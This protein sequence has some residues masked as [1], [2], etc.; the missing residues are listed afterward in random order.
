MYLFQKCKQQYWDKLNEVKTPWVLVGAASSKH[1]KSAYRAAWTLC[2]VYVL[3]IGITKMFRKLLKI[4][5]QQDPNFFLFVLLALWFVY[6]F[7]RFLQFFD[8]GAQS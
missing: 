1:I 8:V 5:N 4:L 6:H 7:S 3:C 2:H